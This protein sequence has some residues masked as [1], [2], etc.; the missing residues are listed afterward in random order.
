MPATLPKSRKTQTEE[1][2]D[3]RILMNRKNDKKIPEKTFWK[4]VYQNLK[5]RFG[6]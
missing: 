5:I 3:F 4:K 2:K 1:E 6:D